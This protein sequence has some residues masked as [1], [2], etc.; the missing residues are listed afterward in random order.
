MTFFIDDDTQGNSIIAVAEATTEAGTNKDFLE[1]K[2]KLFSSGSYYDRWKSGDEMGMIEDLMV[3]D[4]H[5]V[6]DLVFKVVETN[7]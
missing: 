4:T 2:E 7:A 5:E 6:V 1:I 3:D